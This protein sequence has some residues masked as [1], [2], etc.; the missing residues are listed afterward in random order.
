VKCDERKPGCLRCA[1]FGFECEGYEVEKTTKAIQ[2][3]RLV[4]TSILSSPISWSQPSQVLHFQNETEGRYFFYFKD[5]VVPEL[6]TGIALS[7]NLWN[8]VMLQTCHSESF[9]RTAAVA[10][11]ALR[12]SLSS[13]QGSRDA[14]RDEMSSR[15][16]IFALKQWDKALRTMRETLSDREEDL[17]RTLIGCLFVFCF[18]VFLG[19]DATAV[20]HARSGC[21]LLQDWQGPNLGLG[22]SREPLVV[23]DELV[24]A[25]SRLDL[26]TMTTR[27]PGPDEVHDVRMRDGESMVMEMPERFA[28]YEEGY[29]YWEMIMRRSCHFVYWINGEFKVAAENMSI[30]G[31]KEPMGQEATEDFHEKPRRTNSNSSA[32]PKPIPS[33][34]KTEALKRSAEISRWISAFCRIHES[35][36]PSLRSAAAL[37]QVNAQVLQ[38]MIHAQSRTCSSHPDI[39]LSFRSI[40]HFCRIFL[41]LENAPRCPHWRKKETF[42]A[43]IGILPSL[44]LVVNMCKNVELRSEVREFLTVMSG[45]GVWDCE[46]GW[47]WEKELNGKDEVW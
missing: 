1:N 16:F 42:M 23:E 30:A 17:R 3:K 31:L 14:Q 13:S 35:K 22:R 12:M 45:G 9:V 11:A 44:D 37:L 26:Q 5:K 33:H 32:S 34:I 20:L 47:C 28:N 15:H 24:H 6:A 8:Q 39:A 7:S 41:D 18:E 27:V 38:L 19:N 46:E 2:V 29:R 36:S 40:L 43:Y 10:L 21:R 25:F 4:V